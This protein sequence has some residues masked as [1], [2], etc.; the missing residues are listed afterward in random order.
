MNA[1]LEKDAVNPFPGLR[2]F[3][4][5]E[6]HLFF[7]RE[8]QTD[9][10]LLK[11]SQHRFC[12][13]IGPSGS[14]KSSFV[15]CGVLPILYGGFMANRSADWEVVVTR[16]GAG[17]IENLAHALLQHEPD[18]IIAD[19]DEKQIK[20]TIIVTLLRS[21]S[22]GLVEAI[23]QSRK[24]SDRNFLI[25]VDQ[26]EELFR[27]KDSRDNNSINETLAYISLLMEAVNHPDS[28]I[29]VAL[30]MR[31]DFIGECAQFPQLTKKINDSHYL[32]PQLTRDQKKNAIEGPVAV[33]GATIAPR[34]VQQLLNDLGSNPDQLPI[35][36][37]ALMRTYDYWSKYK[38]YED[39]PIDIIHYEAIGTMKEALS[40][41]ANEAFEELNEEQKRICEAVFRAITE[42]RGENFGIRRPTKL[43]E[44]ASIADAPMAEVIEVIDRFRE[45][46]RSLLTPA[47]HI[48]LTEKSIIDISHE[49]L[50]R[51]WVRLK[52]WVD[53]ESEAVQMYLRLAEASAMYQ[54]GKAGL[55]RPPDL[56]LALNWQEKHKPTLVWGQRYHPAF[57]RTLVFL[58]YSKKE[59]ETE[60]RI[61]ELQQKRRL[62]AA[63]ITALI[64]ASATVIS[65]GF[66][67]YAYYQRTEAI[68]NLETATVAQAQAEANELKALEEK[69]RADNEAEIARKNERIAEIQRGIATEQKD[70]ATQA[71][72]LAE[73]KR[74]EAEVA[75]KEAEAAQLVAV[76]NERKA[77]VEEQNARNEKAIADALRHLA[78]AKAL[79][80]KSKEINDPQL[81]GLMAQQ[82][83]N[84][85]TQ[86]GGYPLDNDIYQGLY[87]ALNSLQDPLTQP[88]K[89]HKYQ[90][91]AIVP[92]NADKYLYSAGADG[93]VIQ[94]TLEGTDRRGTEI[95]NRGFSNNIK[96]MAISP[97]NKFLAIG[98]SFPSVN[99][100]SFIELIDI[101]KPSTIIKVEGVQ[102]NVRA[103]KYAKDGK[104]FILDNQGKT[105][106]NYD[107]GQDQASVFINPSS[108]IEDLAI[109][110]DGKF[111]VGA[112]SDGAVYQWKI[113]DKSVIKIDEGKEVLK[114]IAYSP[115]GKFIV[116]GT[117]SGLV[118]VFNTQSRN[119]T[120]LSGQEAIINEI[121]FSPNG[122]LMA[123]ASSDKTV[124]IYNLDELVQKQP[125]VLNDHPDM[126]Q[127][128][129]FTP[130]GEQIVAGTFE[131]L[132]K[133]WPIR[134]EA[135][136]N[137]I[138][139]KVNRNLTQEEWEIYV[140][141][142]IER[143]STCPTVTASLQLETIQNE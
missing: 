117:L 9:E 46:S 116:Y 132:I 1:L 38:D 30:T 54:I 48:E 7:G 11:L 2:P 137:R 80:V 68:K 47:S 57:E 139:G 15:F 31:S 49:S 127:T 107:Q 115:D 82:A 17:P 27:F 89:G 75:K 142:D 125:I 84:Y 18:Y 55:W 99:Q 63:R 20:R 62:K 41:H 19:E 3:K 134:I 78:I 34:L 22:L 131:Q 106:K 121:V 13:I 141:P 24:K 112:S 37:H 71:R 76:R 104:L 81:K 103:L 42:K 143:T 12:G 98:G 64:L 25:L 58:E 94:W 16:P 138:C 5:E 129:A 93:I 100:A 119:V 135:M 118:K 128:I 52:N 130:D 66:L 35:L 77:K 111:I 109:S 61:K 28:P 56:H 32:I 85:N 36:Q 90:V 113:S 65:V 53:D 96:S 39:E 124:R 108:A 50:M 23:Q 73:I 95:A 102:G 69:K 105:I 92:S 140:A 97:N 126:V 79:A 83:Y 43:K 60:E 91:S 136:A 72:A 29:Y 51:I 114:S 101:S 88:L 44:I 122:K 45:P 86:F 110:P 8:G 6:S 40:Q 87:F 33:G 123:T 70:S 67:I 26:F 133:A 120:E 10:V 4:I 74:L 59:F 14:G 21:S